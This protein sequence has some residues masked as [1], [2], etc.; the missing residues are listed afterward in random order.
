MNSK[1][2]LIIF[3]LISLE[4]A[5]QTDT[6]KYPW[7]LSPMTLQRGIGGTFGEYRSTSVDGHYH[8]GVDIGNPGGTPVLAVL[9]GTVAVAYDDGGTGYDSYVRVTATVNGQSK[10]I[11]YYHCRP[12]V[13]VGQAVVVGQQIAK[14]AIDHIH[15]VEYR[16]GGTVTSGHINAIRPNGGLTPFNDTWKP[17]I[18]SIKFY[19]DNSETLVGASSLGNKMDII[20]HV[21]EVTG[22]SSSNSNN[23]TYELGYKILSE[24]RQTVVYNP[25]DDGMRYR[26]YNIPNNSYVNVN[27]F[28]PLATTSTHVYIV[29]NGTG[30]TNIGN[31]QVV[32]NSYWDVT[33]YPY[34]NYTLMVFAKDTRGNA[35]TVYVNVATTDIDLIAPGQ[36]NLKYIRQDSL[37]YFTIAWKKPVDNDLKGYRLFY[38][39]TGSTFSLRENENILTNELTEKQYQYN[40]QNPLFLMI[41]AVDSSTIANLSINSDVYG[42]RIKNDNKKILIVDGFN[43]FG[44]GGSWAYQSHDF[45]IRYSEAFD[46]SYDCAHNTQVENGAIN[47]N[48][49]EAV[50]WMLGDESA[51]DKTFSDAEKSKVSQYLDNGGKL[52][53]S[54]SEIAWDLEGASTATT[55]G[56]KFLREYLKAKYVED[57]S[58]SKIVNGAEGSAFTGVNLSYGIT[59]AGSP[60]P[61]DYP[62]VIDTAN[63]S[64]KVLIYN[65]SKTAGVAYTGNFANPNKT[66]QMVFMSFPFETIGDLTMRKNLMTSIFTYFGILTDVEDNNNNVVVNNFSLS[67]NYPN[68]FNPTTVINY[69]IPVN[70]K[71]S[72]KVYDV[73][74]KE[75]AS[76]VNTEQQSGNYSVS[77]DASKF[78]SGVY[79]YRIIAGNFIQSKKMT[80]LK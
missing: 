48:N 57:N 28:R 72:L 58:N 37:G 40:S 17:F 45:I 14:I 8:N 43:R 49:Y 29:T 55:N 22:P 63:G 15:F 68:P 65:N 39:Q 16:L 56:T 3:L 26:Y 67:Q 44:S 30:A 21:E 64:Q 13:N 9:P 47:L 71:V 75:V 18:R 41:N 62:D 36:S 52:F 79:V 70:S 59:T 77:F 24:D 1:I 46:L 5:A 53:V 78:A 32:S 12:T 38:S 33:Q 25:P 60:Y 6:T 35:D 4:V 50:L 42:I 19:L 10:N 69:Q 23:G 51:T 11:T 80:L 73:L 27:Y 76:L 31:T 34:G 2:I 54:G 61:E 66:G 7:P 20:V 74:G